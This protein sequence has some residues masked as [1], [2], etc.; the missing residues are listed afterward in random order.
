MGMV[1]TNKQRGVTL[2]RWLY[3]KMAPRLRHLVKWLVRKTYRDELC[4]ERELQAMHRYKSGTARF[5]DHTIEFSDALT[6]RIMRE[7]IFNRELYCFETNE[8]APYIIDGGANIGMSVIYFKRRFPDCRVIAFEADP[9]LYAMLNRNC[10]SYGLKDVALKQLALWDEDGVVSFSPEG[11]L[12]GR[13]SEVHGDIHVPSCRLR[14]YLASKVDLLKLD[15][16]GA[17]VKVLRDCRDLLSNVQ[18]IFVEYHA[19]EGKKQE[20]RDVVEIL[21]DAGF[22]LY[23]ESANPARQPFVRR[24]SICGMDIQINLYGFRSRD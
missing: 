12:A 16:E 11:S 10:I 21:D 2:R 17:E 24:N 22:R 14:P 23:V 9:S 1:E 4:Q 3:S 19:L 6:F 20:L 5:Y 18:N 7:E 13:I 15:I 8:K